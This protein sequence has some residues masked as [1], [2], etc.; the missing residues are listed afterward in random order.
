MISFMSI[1]GKDVNEIVFPELISDGEKRDGV[2][3]F[4]QFNAIHNRHINQIFKFMEFVHVF[5]QLITSRICMH[6][7]E[8]FFR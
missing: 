6:A 1:K 8:Y 5:L 4:T 2:F 3:I 7:G